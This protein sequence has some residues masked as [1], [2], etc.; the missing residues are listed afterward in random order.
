MIIGYT[1]PS[2]LDTGPTRRTTISIRTCPSYGN[3]GGGPIT[4]GSAH[5]KENMRDQNFKQP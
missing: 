3:G 5:C 4:N 1:Y 2:V